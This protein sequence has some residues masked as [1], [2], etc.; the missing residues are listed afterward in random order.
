[1]MRVVE[2]T[3]PAHSSLFSFDEFMNFL[4]LGNGA[5]ELAWARAVVGDP[6]HRLLAAYPGFAELPDLAVPS[7]LDDALAL[8]EL[9]AVVV[10]GAFEVRGESLRR[11]AAAGLP[12]ICVHPPGDDAEAYYQVALSREETGAIVIPDLPARLHPALAI[13]RGGF[14]RRGLVIDVDVPASLPTIQAI[15]A[16]VEQLLLNL[17]NNAADAMEAGGRLVIRGRQTGEAV[18]LILED[19]GSGIRAED[20]VKIQEPF[21]T[22]KSS[23]HGLGLAICRSIVSQMRGRLQFESQVGR[24]TRVTLTLPI[25]TETPV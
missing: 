1:M 21:F 4:I 14:E 10:G 7:D 15:Q 5:E 16:D 17:M 23:G 8:A 2:E 22:T 19:T 24:G 20:L 3:F 11:V 9:E 18:E 13:L 6:G 12:A 25:V